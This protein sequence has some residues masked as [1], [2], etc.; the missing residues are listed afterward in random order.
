[1]GI[2]IKNLQTGEFEKFNIPALK[3]E[4]GEPGEIEPS[5]KV[6]YIGKQHSKLRDTMNANVDYIIKTAIGEFNYLDYEGQHITATNSI[7]GHAKSAILS[8]STKYQIGEFIQD[9]Y[10]PVQK[11]KTGY[12]LDWETGVL[13]SGED[14]HKYCEDYIPL[15]TGVTS[16][17][18]K[19]SSNWKKLCCYDSNK[20]FIS[21]V[22]GTVKLEDLTLN[23]PSNAKY[24]RYSIN[25]S[26]G[27]NEYINVVSN[28][29]LL[30][31]SS[32]YNIPCELISCKMPVLTTTGKNLAIVSNVRL[33]GIRSNSGGHPN[34]IIMKNISVEE[35]KT[36]T[37]SGVGSKSDN[38]SDITFTRYEHRNPTNSNNHSQLWN[39]IGRDDS[40][41]T[42]TIPKGIKYVSFTFGNCVYNNNGEDGWL[43]WDSIQLE[44]SSV[45]TSYEPFKTNILS[46]PKEVVLRSLPNGVKDTLNLNTGEYVQRIGEIV[47]NGSETWVADNVGLNARNNFSAYTTIADKKDDGQNTYG[48]IDNST[49]N[50]KLCNG[51]YD[52]L[53]G[54]RGDN[55]GSN[56]MVQKRYLIS[57]AKTK[58]V[59]QDLAGFKAWLQAN[60]VTVQYELATPIIKTVDLSDNHVYSYK[61]TTHYSCSSEEG[62]LVPTLSVKVPTDTQ[63]TIQEQKATTQ[64]LLIKNM[65]LQQS[66]K[67][68]QA[69]NLAFNTA[70]YNSFN[71]I[72]EEVEDIKKHVST[73][74]NLEGSF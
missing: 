27:K 52:Y 24:F 22:N 13:T 32:N 55:E 56:G 1:M 65:D 66:I 47:L 50:N 68:V 21:G 46:T 26:Q 67:E 2:K 20:N 18:S 8:G 33:E 39:E 59:A 63:L 62:T 36:Y 37:I 64:T 73:N 40:N 41:T 3:G 5:E 42:F 60:P 53:T 30:L 70:L 72:R 28:T 74:E 4:K 25:T 31:A 49:L 45:A 61:G 54:S 19:G 44:E 6:D 12:Y 38:M 14:N 10:V 43:Q 9:V 17:T 69:M 16:I 23:I 7:E 11:F 29:G 15:P 34:N 57:I 58:L 48:S 51:A 71:D 35:G